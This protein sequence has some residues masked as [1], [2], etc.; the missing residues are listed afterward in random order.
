MTFSAYGIW[1]RSDNEYIHID[2]IKRDGRLIGLTIYQLQD[3]GQ[4]QGVRFARSAR[5]NQDHW[6]LNQATEIN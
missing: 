6:I 2:R 3:K 1:A 4:L 5:F